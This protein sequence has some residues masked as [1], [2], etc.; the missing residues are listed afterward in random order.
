MTSGVLACGSLA[1]D[2]PATLGTGTDC[3]VTRPQAARHG[4]RMVK[5]DPLPGSLATVIAPPMSWQNR[6]LMASPRPVPP[7][8]RVVVAST[9]EKGWNSLC[10]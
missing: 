7:Y 5:V 3:S 9:C 1:V 6:W 10:N 8:V 2:A 4:N